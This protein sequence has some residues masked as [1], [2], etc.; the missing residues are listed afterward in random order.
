MKKLLIVIAW[1]VIMVGGFYLLATNPNPEAYGQGVTIT[2]TRVGKPNTEC[3][4][5]AYNEGEDGYPDSPIMHTIGCDN[6]GLVGG[7]YQR[8]EGECY[9]HARRAYR[10]KGLAAN[11]VELKN[12]VESFGCTQW[13]DG[14]YSLN[15]SK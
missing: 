15:R 12:Y 13:E 11:S 6:N 8:M 10:S 5:W 3:Q 9:L 4:R 1:L 2:V 14:T 7:V